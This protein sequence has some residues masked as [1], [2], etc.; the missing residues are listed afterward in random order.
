MNNIDDF[1]NEIRFFE[2]MKK[3]GDSKDFDEKLKH[4]LEFVE[5][6]YSIVKNSSF[7]KVVA[8]IDFFNNNFPVVTNY[9]LNQ[10]DD[11]VYRA[12]LVL[13]KFN[14]IDPLLIKQD[15]EDALSKHNIAAS[16]RHNDNLQNRNISRKNYEYLREYLKDKKDEDIEEQLIRDLELFGSKLH[17]VDRIVFGLSSRSSIP[18]RAY[19]INKLFSSGLSIETL[20]EIFNEVLL[21][22]PY[23]KSF[24]YE[25]ICF[26]EEKYY[27]KIK[28]LFKKFNDSFFK[29][30]AEATYNR[31]DFEEFEED[32]R[33]VVELN[34]D[35][36]EGLRLFFSKM[37]RNASRDF[38]DYFKDK[39]FFI[40]YGNDDYSLLYEDTLNKLLNGSKD[41]DKNVLETIGEYK[42]F[43]DNFDK[44]LE[45]FIKSNDIEYQRL[46]LMPLTRGLIEIQKRKYDVD[47]EVVYSTATVSASVFGSYN[48]I[49]KRLY[50]NP[51]VFEQNESAKE[52]LV[53]AFEVVF[54]E[55]RHAYEDKTVETSD[56]ISFDNL[57]LAMDFILARNESGYDHNNYEVL[58]YERDA[59]ETSYVDLMTLFREYPEMQQ[60]CKNKLND[61]GPLTD[62][63]RKGQTLEELVGVVF[64]F[65]NNINIFFEGCKNGSM[66]Y[67]SKDKTC[68][69]LIQE[70]IELLRSYPV[71]KNFFDFDE[72]N[73]VISPKSEE[74]FR[75]KLESLDSEKDR[76]AIYSIKTFMYAIKVSKHLSDKTFEYQVNETSE[77][78][79]IEDVINNVGP[80]PS[81]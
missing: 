40:K 32:L 34:K 24:D 38:L 73:L 5:H 19:I 27:T 62:F 79:I 11:I 13:E 28:G 10:N 39:D 9:L 37:K 36:E 70:K 65:V 48:Y 64:E 26:S 58:S 12:L 35:D 52:S 47:F 53:K 55:T 6:V 43:I 22:N 21:K 7:E 15:M 46:L 23:L 8:I 69:Q 44:L 67:Y 17:N 56:S 63:I 80:R 1:L 42:G 2:Y 68:E 72:E 75:R 57:L 33:K 66:E 18:P 3:M 81:R 61:R 20:S 74:Y 29:S 54:H 60:L 31:K 51:L 16:L 30:L 14:E 76:E 45:L 4:Y 49:E 25:E 59:F 71:I 41:V 78:D 50:V 77:N